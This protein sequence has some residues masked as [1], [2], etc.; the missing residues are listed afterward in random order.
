MDR[1]DLSLILFGKWELAFDVLDIYIRTAIS[2]EKGSTK[3]ILMKSILVDVCQGVRVRLFCNTYLFT[4]NLEL[5]IDPHT[6]YIKQQQKSYAY[7][8]KFTLPLF[9]KKIIE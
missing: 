7:S 8:K 1:F 3:S 9:P 4:V 6:P 2:R 5:R